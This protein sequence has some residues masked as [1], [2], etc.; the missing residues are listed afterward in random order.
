M[1]KTGEM[2]RKRGSSRNKCEK[3]RGKGQMMEGC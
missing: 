2:N 3:E 1:D